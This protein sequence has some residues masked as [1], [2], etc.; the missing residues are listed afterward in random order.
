MRAQLICGVFED[1]FPANSELDAVLKEID[2]QDYEGLCARETHHGRGYTDKFCPL[3]EEGMQKALIEEAELRARGQVLG[4]RLMPPRSL[5]CFYAWLK[6]NPSDAGKRRVIDGATWKGM[7]SAMADGHTYEGRQRNK[8]RT[9]LS[10]H[11]ENHRLLA[12]RVKTEGWGKIRKEVHQE[13]FFLQNLGPIHVDASLRSKRYEYGLYDKW[14]SRFD[15]LFDDDDLRQTHQQAHFYEWIGAIVLHHLTGYDAL[16][17]KYG[18]EAHGPHPKKQEVIKRLSLPNHLRDLMKTTH[19]TVMCPDLLMY[20]PHD[21]SKWFFCEIKGPG[22]KLQDNQLKF[23][24]QLANADG[25]PIFVLRFKCKDAQLLGLPLSEIAEGLK[26]AQAE[27][28]QLGSQIQ[29]GN[30]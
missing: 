17:E 20:R 22:D 6:L 28:E 13:Y 25:K 27:L 12:D 30:P 26:I 23:F 9:I 24:E 19:R 4:L 16:V 21:L 10:G 1:I 3:A 15:S 7:P 11:T 14:R 2:C 8:E 18:F 29:F 5:N